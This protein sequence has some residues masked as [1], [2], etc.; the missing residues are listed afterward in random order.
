[1]KFSRA[2]ACIC[3]TAL[4]VL[5]LV[6]CR[7]TPTPT[8]EPGTVRLDP[9]D[10]QQVWVPAGSGV[11]ERRQQTA[12]SRQPTASIC[13]HTLFLSGMTEAVLLD[14]AGR[15]VKELRPGENDVRGIAPGVYFVRGEGPGSRVMIA[16]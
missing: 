7:A 13:R 16:D 14:I 15:R 4:V 9:K 6:G 10:I 11:A 3:W 5:Y 2:F 1:M 8:P 12:H